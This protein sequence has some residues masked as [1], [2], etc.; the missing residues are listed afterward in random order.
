MAGWLLE[1]FAVRMKLVLGSWWWVESQSSLNALP[2]VHLYVPF[3]TIHKSL[4]D[5]SD[6]RIK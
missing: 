2:L 6:A 4:A 5:L 3:L 1:L